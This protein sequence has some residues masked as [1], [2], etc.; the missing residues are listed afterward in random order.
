LEAVTMRGVRDFIVCAG[1]LGLIGC[2]PAADAG[3][4]TL[5]VEHSGFDFA[6]TGWS[7][8]DIGLQPD[9]LPV[10]PAG[11]AASRGKGVATLLTRHLVGDRVRFLYKVVNDPR[12]EI[13]IKVTGLTASPSDP[14]NPPNPPVSPP[15]GQV[16]VMIRDGLAPN[17]RM[18]SGAWERNSYTDD[19]AGLVMNKFRVGWREGLSENDVFGGVPYPG[20]DARGHSPTWAEPAPAPDPQANV[21]TPIWLRLQRQGSGVALSRS[22]DGIS[23]APMSDTYGGSDFFP[24]TAGPVYLGV[25]VAGFDPPNDPPDN[26]SPTTTT[27]DIAEVTVSEGAEVD[28]GYRTSWIGGTENLGGE[29]AITPGILSALYVAPSGTAYTYGNGDWNRQRRRIHDASTGLSRPTALQNVYF[30][31]GGDQ[32]AFT[33]DDSWIYFVSKGGAGFCV[34][35]YEPSDLGDVAPGGPCASVSNSVAGL[36]GGAAAI[37]PGVAGDPR[38]YVTNFTTGQ[39]HLFGA[40]L[41]GTSQLALLG[42]YQLPIPGGSPPSSGQEAIRP[43]AVA[44]RSIEGGHRIWVLHGATPYGVLGSYDRELGALPSFIAAYDIDPNAPP[45]SAALATAA[46]IPSC[47][48]TAPNVSNCPP[49]NAGAMC[50]TNPTALA[51][52]R[53]RDRLLVAENGPSQN[54]HLFCSLQGT[55]P[56]RCA[57]A[58]FGQEGGVF[59]G[60]PGKVTD[61]GGDARFHALSGVGVDADGAIYVASSG[62]YYDL[63]KYAPNGNHAVWANQGLLIPSIDFDPNSDGLDVYSARQHFKLNLGDGTSAT[64]QVRK[65]TSIQY[66]PGSEW[67]FEGVTWDPF[68]DPLTGTVAYAEK[69]EHG[70]T[71]RPSGAPIIRWIGD[72]RYMFLGYND[73]PFVTPSGPA[74]SGRRNEIRIYRFQGT[75]R[76]VPVGAIRVTTYCDWELAADRLVCA[77]DPNC[78]C[79]PIPN[80]PGD[81]NTISS[82]AVLAIW[83]DTNGNGIEDETP[84][85]TL[86]DLSQ[87]SEQDSQ[88]TA[89]MLANPPPTD[90]FH[91]DVD[92]DGDL[93]LSFGKDE[94]TE[95]NNNVVLARAGIWRIRRDESTSQ[96]RYILPTAE[97]RRKYTVN[98]L[99]IVSGA[100]RFHR[101]PDQ[102]MYILSSGAVHRVDSFLSDQRFLKI[103]SIPLPVQPPQAEIALSEFARYN[104][105]WRHFDVA[106][107]KIFVGEFFGP[108]SVY[109]ANGGNFVTRLFAN[110]DV[111]GFQTENDNNLRA[112]KRSNGEYLVTVQDTGGRGRALLFRWT[113][114]GG[115]VADGDCQGPNEFCD[116]GIC[117]PRSCS[118]SDAFGSMSPV[119]ATGLEADGIAIAPNGLSAVISRKVGTNHAL[120]S[121]TRASTT[122]LFDSPDALESL[123][124]TGDERSPWLS[125]DGGTLYFHRPGSVGGTDLFVATRSSPAAEFLTSA[126]VGGANSPLNDEDPFLP[127]GEGKLFFSS[128]RGPGTDLYVAS[129]SGT[130]FLAPA[131]LSSV[132]NSDTYADTRP[133]VTRDGLSLYF[134]SQRPSA[135]ND[136]DGDIWLAQWNAA[137]NDF[138]VPANLSS[139]N[140]SGID[141]PVSLSADGCS[142]YLA[143]NRELGLGSTQAFRLYRAQRQ[144]SPSQVTVTVHVSGSGSVGTPFACDASGGT[145]TAQ[146]AFGDSLIVEASSPALWSGNCGPNGAAGLSGDG[147]VPFTLNSTCTVTFAPP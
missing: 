52:D 106:G 65:P 142:L 147:V 125:M 79:N 94:T 126:L 51:Y 63:R 128:S 137:G 28:Y 1:I 15:Q 66:Q 135:T 57:A 31:G 96:L 8:A 113:P 109:D 91:F 21:R 139:L 119:L 54:I 114:P 42:S 112:F 9:N 16:G 71:A 87:F 143:S 107:D 84:D 14:N 132:V 133:V 78:P 4:E 146:R 116:A 120:F 88:W 130:G 99:G 17:A 19:Q 95:F 41:S 2:A 50:V 73:W 80:D 76:A 30:D 29:T 97:E 33:G 105:S 104:A 92:S 22:F 18:V 122:G 90:T 93:W 23:W 6:V 40:P 102:S 12:A 47:P 100:I 134:G 72:D 25:F 140:T 61:G 136:T 39:V 123:N 138:G 110:A 59:C 68:P 56:V 98:Q 118:L 89:A 49:P 37:T 46:T 11:I 58:S 111:S 26:N 121:V 67:S 70:A 127:S 117:R 43:Q 69:D 145:C 55:T 3:D 86:N 36:A 77:Q 53:W 85:Y 103:P 62:P 75:E 35:A 82:T 48:A 141:F 32:N 144:A 108:V 24:A 129:A 124:T 101:D 131:R 44:A 83:N 27:A 60:T 64:D 20:A 34:H 7:T 10:P 13:V 74:G 38:V 81:Q 45:P 115:C 5:A